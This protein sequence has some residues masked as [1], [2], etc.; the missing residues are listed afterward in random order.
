MM[1]FFLGQITHQVGKSE[2]GNEVFKG[3]DTFQASNTINFDNAPV[4]YLW[5]QVS[6]LRV[7]QRWVATPTGSTFQ[8]C[9]FFH[10]SPPP[11]TRYYLSFLPRP[12]RAELSSSSYVLN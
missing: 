11:L 4:R 3:E 6:Y 1:A 7:C 5:L 8:L 9:Q 10:C 2:R 12:S